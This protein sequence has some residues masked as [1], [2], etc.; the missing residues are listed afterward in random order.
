[1]LINNFNV[2]VIVWLSP[3]SKDLWGGTRTTQ[4]KVFHHDLSNI[5]QTYFESMKA[6]FCLAFC[7]I[8]GRALCTTLCF[9]RIGTGHCWQSA[10]AKWWKKSSILC[11]FYAP[12]WKRN[13]PKPV[14][15]LFPLHLRSDF[16][17]K[18]KRYSNWEM[19]GGQFLKKEKM[20]NQFCRKKKIGKS[21]L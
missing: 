13:L 14:F 7:I 9:S 6:G 21:V 8:R 19:L 4:R 2:I 11:S 15:N 18:S 3:I 12:L 20:G 10:A 5:L 16:R 17:E 1:M